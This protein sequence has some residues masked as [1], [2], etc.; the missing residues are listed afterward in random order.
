MMY[1][2]VLAASIPSWTMGEQNRGEG[3]QAV[4]HAVPAIVGIYKPPLN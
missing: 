1:P 2:F 4:W 3:E